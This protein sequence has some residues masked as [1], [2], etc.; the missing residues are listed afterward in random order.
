MSGVFKYLLGQVLNIE[1][2]EITIFCQLKYKK[3]SKVNNLNLTDLEKGCVCNGIAF[4]IYSAFNKL[5]I[6]YAFNHPSA[7]DIGRM[8]DTFFDTVDYP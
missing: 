2:K 5:I 1:N 7:E 6:Y 8:D 4:P 3:L